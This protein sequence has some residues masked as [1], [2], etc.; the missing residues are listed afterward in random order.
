MK[1][2]LL[3]SV[4]VAFATGCV[5]GEPPEPDAGPTT[6]PEPSAPAF[7]CANG[8]DDAWGGNVTP[9]DYSRFAESGCDTIIGDL[10][11][12]P[13]A[14]W[15]NDVLGGE[16]DNATNP[17][18]V[19]GYL[20]LT[21]EDF[22]QDETPGLGYWFTGIQALGV[23]YTDSRYI[24]ATPLVAS[25][26]VPWGIFVQDNRD[27]EELDL[28][29]FSSICDES[30]FETSEEVP[31]VEGFY[32]WNNPALTTIHS[33]NSTNFVW[34]TCDTAAPRRLVVIDNPLLPTAE[35][36]ALAASLPADVELR[37]CG[38]LEDDPCD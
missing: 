38:N 32:I 35:I 18:E 22:D 36:D 16:L 13:N 2:V 30:P 7:D 15:F 23:S 14:E 28:R 31:L 20:R 9:D 17:I 10:T 24:T 37:H 4:F 8:D 6:D 29:P 34:G 21:D 19:H 3:L 12:V 11:V 1:A 25:G 26:P 27:L 33:R 5:T